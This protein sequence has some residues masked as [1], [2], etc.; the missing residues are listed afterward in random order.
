MA[1]TASGRFL[2][3]AEEEF[4]RGDLLQASEKAWGAVA[5][6]VKSVAKARGWRDGSH[7][8]VNVNAERLIVRTRDPDGNM[9][10]FS[11]IN[12]LHVNFYEITLSERS[13]RIGIED[14][15]A[16]VAEMKEAEAGLPPIA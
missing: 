14:A 8:D 3:Q 7:R 5:H 6:Y 16:L 1:T 15:R 9:R 4:E 13:V 2:E 10:K 12:N 11:H